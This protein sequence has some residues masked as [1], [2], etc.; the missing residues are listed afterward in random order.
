MGPHGFYGNQ[1]AARIGGDAKGLVNSLQFVFRLAVLPGSYFSFGA[2]LHAHAGSHLG[3]HHTQDLRPP[4]IDVFQLELVLRDR[5]NPVG[6]DGKIEVRLGRIVSLVVDGPDLQF[7]LQD[8]EGP[9][10]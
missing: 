1:G 4:Y 10:F 9:Q 5:H 7:T 3:A 8:L 2:H 6:K